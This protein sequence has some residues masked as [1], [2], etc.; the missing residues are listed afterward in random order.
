MGGTGQFNHL[1]QLFQAGLW[2]AHPLLAQL[3][4]KPTIDARYW[5]PDTH[6][7]M[8]RPKRRE[9]DLLDCT[10][11]VV[12]GNAISRG[13][14]LQQLRDFGMTAVEAANR[15]LEARSKLETKPFEIVLCE[16]RFP[17]TDY[18]GQELLDDLRRAQILPYGTVFV[19]L[20]AEATYAQ[21]SEAAESALD[22]YLLKPH[23]AGGL[24][25]RLK[26]AHQRKV[27]LADIFEAIEAGDF[28]TAIQHCLTRYRARAQYW[29][30]AG[31]VAAELLM[32]EG[33]P[34]EAGDLYRSIAAQQP[35][36]W[37]RLGV[38]R[39]QLEASKPNEALSSLE[40]LAKDQPAF[41]D[42]FDVLVRLHLDNSQPAAALEAAKR[43]ADITPGSVDRLQRYGMLA[44]YQ[45]DF[46]EAARALDR[47]TL[48][49]LTSKLYD[50][51]C[52]MLLTFAR[53]QLKDAQG[54]K[55]CT[56]QIQKL[57]ERQENPPR[58][59]RFKA[60]ANTLLLLANKQLAAVVEE[61]KVHA[62]E[63]RSP[64]FDVEAACNFL[65]LI[66]EIGRS[67][68][69]LEVA[70]EWVNTLAQRFCTSSSL[71][72]LLANAAARHPP[73]A[74]AVRAGYQRIG[75]IAQVAMALTI[76]GKPADTVKTLLSQCDTT[77]NLKLME[78]ARLTLERHRA[79]IP[80][81]DAL[82]PD[83]Q[84]RLALFTP[85]CVTPPM[86]QAKGRSAGGLKLRT[87][88][89]APAAK[90]SVQV[91]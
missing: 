34:D 22:S 17:D 28:G 85:S 44:Y 66:S 21:V 57:M 13:V 71:T 63:L 36:P 69:S 11:L 41:A 47:A 26:H 35:L 53:L 38:A 78:T 40:L 67:E 18:T 65:A 33:K 83:I 54:I 31:R 48:L 86:G 87:A 3:R 16:Q 12:D 27:Q 89:E 49:G 39:S 52:L 24:L 6:L 62:Q 70:D 72:D 14:I 58:L 68:L 7:A 42:T 25:E 73:Y 61:V 37:A 20:T 80:D 77:L 60:M 45:G 23:T 64:A 75:A 84:A 51:Q 81:A 91:D 90:P 5:R 15:P 82:E 59:V 10:A 1:C 74:A 19:M 46:A 88:K 4:Y 55:R 2:A 76:A 50:A 29:L 9:P 8:N 32:R 30:F 79:R 43:A 56:D